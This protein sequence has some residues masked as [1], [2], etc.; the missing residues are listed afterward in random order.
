MSGHTTCS[1]SL[2]VTM[3][4]GWGPEIKRNSLRLDPRFALAKARAAAC[5]RADRLNRQPGHAC[6]AISSQ[7]DAYASEALERRLVRPDK[8]KDRP[9][10]GKDLQLVLGQFRYA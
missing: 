8:R 4:R 6:P 2:S 9:G 3:P 7:V 1:E 5:R 10:K